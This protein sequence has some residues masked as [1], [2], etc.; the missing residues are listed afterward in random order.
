MPSAASGVSGL[1][2]ISVM[3]ADVLAGGEA[4]DE[5]VELEDEADRLA[6]VT[7]ELLLVGVREVDVAVAQRAG[8]RDVEAAELVE[9]GRL[10][11]ARGTEQH[12]EFAGVQVQVHAGQGAH[13]GGAGAVDLGQT[14]HVENRGAASGGGGRMGGG[15]HAGSAAWRGAVGAQS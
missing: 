2:A 11:R 7:G 10:A 4:R 12:D 9:E 14:T 13:L 3:R 8:G 15:V 1:L 6:P 5:V